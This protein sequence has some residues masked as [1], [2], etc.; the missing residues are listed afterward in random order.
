MQ[1]ALCSFDQ[2]TD[3][4]FMQQVSKKFKAS[5]IVGFVWLYKSL[6]NKQLCD[7]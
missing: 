7:L 5:S 1:A 3:L 4:S 2:S 6:S